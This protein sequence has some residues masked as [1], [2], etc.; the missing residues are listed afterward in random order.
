MAQ[1]GANC[2][3]S[4]STNWACNRA[5]NRSDKSTKYGIVFFCRFT[6]FGGKRGFCVPMLFP[7]N[8][9]GF[10]TLASIAGYA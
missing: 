9:G 10:F 6:L 7:Y 3:Y 1:F 2:C 5:N 4:K 8:T